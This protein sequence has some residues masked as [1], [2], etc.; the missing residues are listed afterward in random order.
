MAQ[1]SNYTLILAAIENYLEVV[2]GIGQVHMYQRHVGDWKQMLA[3]F[4]TGT[5]PNVRLNGWMVSRRAVT[6]KRLTNVEVLRT[7]T[8]VLRGVMG[9]KDSANTESTFQLL[10][11]A[12]CDSFRESVT[13]I[14]AAETHEPASFSEIG[15]RMFGGVLC[16]YCEGTLLV[17]E[18]LQG[19]P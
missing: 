16:H 14:G 17:N 9:V 4:T 6:E 10:V 1:A 8:F 12:V 13:L 7:H 11:E 2:V 19:G 15:Y 18:R 3:T 5:A